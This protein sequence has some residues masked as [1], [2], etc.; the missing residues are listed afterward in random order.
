ML[1]KQRGV[2]RGSSFT[3]KYRVLRRDALVDKVNNKH[4]GQR[5]EDPELTIF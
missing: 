4:S 3:F 5:A 2:V 1:S